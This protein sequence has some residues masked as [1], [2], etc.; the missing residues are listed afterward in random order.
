[1]VYN[2]VYTINK[3]P[4]SIHIHHMFIDSSLLKHAPFVL[5][6]ADRHGG[7]ERRRMAG[8]G[9]AAQGSR[10][11]R[12]GSFHGDLIRDFMGILI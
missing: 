3:R 9:H 12:H 5:H 11:G 2:G 7:T 10:G 8:K 4:I 6:V 1:M